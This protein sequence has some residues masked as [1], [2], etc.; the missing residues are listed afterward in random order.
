MQ[1]HRILESNVR[2]WP[3]RCTFMGSFCERRRS[4]TVLT[5]CV[6]ADNLTAFFSEIASL[7]MVAR[8]PISSSISSVVSFVHSSTTSR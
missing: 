6:L 8:T 2:I 5:S 3:G 4:V 7:G 1:T